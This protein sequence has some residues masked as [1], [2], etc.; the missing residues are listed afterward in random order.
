[1]GLIYNVKFSQLSVLGLGLL[2]TPTLISRLQSLLRRWS[3]LQGIISPCVGYGPLHGRRLLHSPPW[4]GERSLTPRVPTCYRTPP[5]GSMGRGRH[6]RT[7]PCTN[8]LQFTRE[9]RKHWPSGQKWA[10]QSLMPPNE[11]RTGWTYY[12]VTCRGF[13]LYMIFFKHVLLQ[14][15]V[16][17]ARIKLMEKKLGP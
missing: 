1:M 3:Q 15:P 16:K 13:I 8:I 5:P 14:H 10:R 7:E 4:D 11:T 9:A 2:T 17:Q 6:T 12:L